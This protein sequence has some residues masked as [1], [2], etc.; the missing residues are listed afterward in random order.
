MFKT[1]VAGSDGQPGCAAVRVAQAIA[2]ATGARLVTVPADP[3][4]ARLAE[5]LAK[6]TLD[7][8]PARDLRAV[9]DDEHADLIVVGVPH[10]TPRQRLVRTD[11]ALQVLHDAPCAVVAV[12]DGLAA[13]HPLERIGVGIDRSPE[14]ATALAIALELAR[15]GGAALHLFAVASDL[16]GGSRH[17]LVVGA[18]YLD[19]YREILDARVRE[20][21]EDLERALQRCSGVRV[22]DDV[23]VGDPAHALAALSAG[24]DLLVLGSRRWGTLRRL[25]LGSTSERVI[26]YARCPVLVPPRGGGDDAADDR[27]SHDPPTLVAPA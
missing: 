25:A 22:T 6:L 23:C 27:R 2:A 18:A 7:A 21:H 13:P 12:P 8:S 1:I 5:G 24:C 3:D 15:A 14:S 26:H 10:R 19:S 11:H 4:H 16:Y 20:A 9:A 17:L